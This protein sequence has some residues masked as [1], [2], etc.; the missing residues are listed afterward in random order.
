MP[1]PRKPT[2]LKLIT[3][4][5]QPCRMNPNEPQFDVAI[6]KPPHHLSKEARKEWD[7]M[8]PVLFDMGLISEC[9]RAAFAMYCQ[10]WGR[11]VKAEYMIR[12][13]GP[14]ITTKDGLQKVSPWV[15]ISHE[16]SI[17]AQRLL[18]EF[19]L[20]PAAR[21]RVVAKKKETKDPK[22]RFFK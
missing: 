6:P 5:A 17:A 7:R 4:T 18:I 10:S 15:R 13:H 8:A 12:I 16:A 22:S 1:K 19:G 14:V 21:S 2:T 20:T 3:G 11:H 9:D